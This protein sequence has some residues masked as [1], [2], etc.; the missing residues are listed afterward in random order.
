M[1]LFTYSKHSEAWWYDWESSFQFQVFYHQSILM[2]SLL[3]LTHSIPHSA[4]FT[5]HT[6]PSNFVFY[7]IDFKT[8]KKKK[9][10]KCIY[11]FC[12]I[13]IFYKKVAS[14]TSTVYRK[15]RLNIFRLWILLF[16]LIKVKAIFKTRME[17]SDSFAMYLFLVWSSGLFFRHLR[18]MTLGF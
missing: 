14:L 3:G 1:S 11:D 18:H 2:T 17:R 4:S 10:I 12:W 9:K 8:R 6:N 7:F 13:Y 16:V 15:L 5:Q